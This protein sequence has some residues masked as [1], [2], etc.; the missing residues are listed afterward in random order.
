MKRAMLVAVVGVVGCGNGSRT[1]ATQSADTQETCVTIQRGTGGTVA[2]TFIKSNVMR[3]NFGARPHLRV[4]KRDESLIRFDLSAIPS[5]VAIT[6]ASLKLF[7]NGERGE[8]T[9][10]LHRVLAPWDESTV[11]YRSF[12][13]AYAR[14]IA[15]AFVAESRNTVKTVDL[16][17]LVTAWTSGAQPNY[18]VL[19]RPGPDHPGVGEECDEDNDPTIFVSS[20]GHNVGRRPALEVC[21]TTI[22]VDPCA[23]NP[24][25]NGG[26]CTAQG[27]SYTCQCAL[28]YTGTNCETNIDDCASSPCQHGGTCTDGVGGYTCAC[29]PGYSGANCET[30]V[31][32]CDPNPCQNDGVCQDGVN[33]YKCTCLNGYDGANCEHLIDNCA[34]NPCHNGGTCTNGV[35]TYTCTC[36]A[37]F[38]GEN[39]DINTDDCIANECQNG[40]TCIDGID[41]YTCACA[42]DWGGQFCDVNLNE[43]ALHPCLNGA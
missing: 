1:G 22:Q 23:G 12:Q 42:P 28:G 16:T 4:S 8:G 41:S 20:E 30:D 39:C 25:Q 6:R 10:E 14:D 5:G 31:N 19:L 40:A 24:C 34:S 26:T 38:E 43:C 33:S 37:G 29:V 17:S 15:G 9:T 18:G 27:D 13:Q 35:G 36:A 32:D 21:F 3:H 7:V 11:T 2:D